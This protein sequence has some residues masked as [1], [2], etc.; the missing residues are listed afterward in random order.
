[1]DQDCDGIPDDDSLG[2]GSLVLTELQLRA[3]PEGPWIELW[4]AHSS[5]RPLAGLT[6]RSDTATRVLPANAP[7]LAPGAHA[8]IC[9]DAAAAAAAGLSCAL[10]LEDWPWAPTGGDAI[11][12]Q[13]DLRTLDSLRWSAS[14]PLSDAVAL[15][16]DPAVL[17]GPSPDAAND[18]VGAW[19]PAST[20]GA[21]SLGTPGAANPPCP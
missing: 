1:M 17:A 9:G 7:V 8:V 6:L 4:S 11:Q 18:S 5:D 20:G 19:C 3:A 21:P 10:V 15:Q 13:A 14:W 12:I 2:P 16:L